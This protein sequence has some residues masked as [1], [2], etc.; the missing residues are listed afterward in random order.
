L[1]FLLLEAFF[2]FLDCVL[3]NFCAEFGLPAVESLLAAAAWFL[4]G[5]CQFGAGE[6]I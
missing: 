4:R 3:F 5:H 1:G 2:F 6:G